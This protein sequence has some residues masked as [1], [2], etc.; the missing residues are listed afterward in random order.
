MHRV[1]F[2]NFVKTEFSKNI[3]KH[4]LAAGL[5]QGQEKS[6]KTKKWQ[7][8]GKNGGFWKKS[9]NLTKFSKISGFVSSDLPNSLYLKAF[10]W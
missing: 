5:P 7:K 9:G 6:G 10:E 8:S 2:L 3:K 1:F 4:F